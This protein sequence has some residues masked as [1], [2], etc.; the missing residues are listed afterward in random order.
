MLNFRKNSTISFYFG[1]LSKLDSLQKQKSIYYFAW[2]NHN[3]ELALQYWSYQFR[4]VFITQEQ[5]HRNN[6]DQ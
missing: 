6:D 2:Q 5:A 1:L 3:T 4:L